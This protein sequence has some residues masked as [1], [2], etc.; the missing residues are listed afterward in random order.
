VI[1]RFDEAIRL[2]PDYVDA[3]RNLAQ[4]LAKKQH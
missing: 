4:V 2:R 1:F 3:R